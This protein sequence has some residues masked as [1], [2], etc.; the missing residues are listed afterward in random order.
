[1]GRGGPMTPPNSGVVSPGL[2]PS[3]RPWFSRVCCPHLLRDLA[4]PPGTLVCPVWTQGCP[5]RGQFSAPSTR[6]LL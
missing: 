2:A 1:M 4:G 3:S 5:P 6:F